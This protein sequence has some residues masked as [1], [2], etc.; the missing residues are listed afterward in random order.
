MALRS[1]HAQWPIPNAPGKIHRVVDLVLHMPHESVPCT[2]ARR[3]QVLHAFFLQAGAQF[4]FTSALGTIA[5]MTG[6]QVFVERSVLLPSAGRHEIGNA[7]I[8]ADHRGTCY[9]L[10]RHFLIIGEREPPH[11]VPL[12]ELHAGVELLHL[13]G[14]WVREGCFV[15]RSEFDGHLDRLTFLQGC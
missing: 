7:H 13:V 6:S 15:I 11:A 1:R 5:L 2:T 14:L 8:N 10:Y 12:I 4:G 3:G 9:G